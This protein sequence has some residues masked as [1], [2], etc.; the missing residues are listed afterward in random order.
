MAL[1][2]DG[3]T[4]VYQVQGP[5]G[6]RLARRVMSDTVGTV[7]PGTEGGLFFALSPDAKWV[8]Y[9][10]GGSLKKVPIEGGPP[11]TIGTFPRVS[12]MSWGPNDVIVIA[13]KNGIGGLIQVTATAGGEVRQFAF[14]DTAHGEQGMRWPRLLADGKTVLYTSWPANDLLSDAHIGIASLEGGEHTILDVR[15]AYAFGVFDGRLVYARPDGPIMSVPIDVRRRRVLREPS[16]LV[17][18]VEMGLAGASKATLSNNGTLLY[19]TGGNN[20][21]LVVV[22]RSGGARTLATSGYQYQQPRISPNGKQIA[23]SVNDIAANAGDIL[24]IDRDGTMKGK[25]PATDSSR[26]R[27]APEWALDGKRLLFLAGTRATLEAGASGRLVSQPADGSASAETIGDLDYKSASVGG[28][29]L[30]RDGR[31]LVWTTRRNDM[32]IGYRSL[33]DADTTPKPLLTSSANEFAP[34][35]SPDGKWLAYVSDEM[36]KEEVYVRAFPGPPSKSKVSLDGGSQ[37]R[38][39]SDGR[40]IY[41]RSETRLIEAAVTTS[42]TFAVGVRTP[43]FDDPYVKNPRHSAEYDVSPNGAE[44]V[45]IRRGETESK[46]LGILNFQ[47]VLAR[48]RRR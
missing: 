43:L 2:S 48:A 31:T 9:L 37:P 7:I 40:H 33:A 34:A 10:A 26:W 1:S 36:G 11:T 19:Q 29:A 18:G 22:D 16:L 38:W 42:P 3:R 15:G 8:V 21:T 28:Y 35:L 6:T 20:R 47:T 46:V 30:S 39:S 5:K 14:P 45:M 4:L 12:Q 17:A 41:Y 24:V 27:Y 32:D 25:L 23:V 44:F 13:A